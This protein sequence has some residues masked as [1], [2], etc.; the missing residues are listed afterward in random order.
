MIPSSR[1]RCRHS[2]LPFRPERHSLSRPTRKGSIARSR[3]I[4]PLAD[5]VDK[6]SGVPNWKRGVDILLVLLILPIVALL[7]SLVYC[8]VQL[9][10]PGAAL[11]RQTRIG[12]GGKPFTIY[13]FRSMNLRTSTDIHEEHVE[14]LIKSN[15][16]LIKLDVI[17]DS[18]LIK[19]GYLL[20]ISG[21]DE[22]PQ[23]INVLRGEMSLVGPRPCLPN[24]FALYDSHQ[25]LRF[26]VQ[27]G[28]TGLW[29]INRTSSTTFCEMVKMDKDYVEHLSAMTD[30]QIILRT[31]LALIG[32]MKAGAV[33][34]TKN[35]ARRP[36]VVQTSSRAKPSPVYDL[37]MSSTQRISD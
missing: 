4:P 33:S 31:P 8:W 19:G 37:S 9:V 28:L 13:K 22:L 10:S 7:G 30:F 27:P 1:R 18:R 12:R 15:K 23:F 35:T 24:E 21:L 16:P 26:A 3:V 36:V 34:R 25:R 29:Q 20:R 14:H 11:F 17:G 2:F 5:G 6:C 32:Q